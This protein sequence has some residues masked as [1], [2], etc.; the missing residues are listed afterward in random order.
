MGVDEAKALA[1]V[2]KSA[3]LR[4]FEGMNHI[5]KEVESDRIKNIPIQKER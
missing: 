5:L 1:L 2:N 3:E 4:I